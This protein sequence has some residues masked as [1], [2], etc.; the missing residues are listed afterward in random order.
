MELKEATKL[1]EEGVLSRPGKWAD[2]GCGSGLFTYALAT[3]LGRGSTVYA[4][5]RD[6]HSIA[7]IE[8]ER[9]G[10][11]I[12]KHV[13]NFERGELP[14][15]KLDGILLANALHFVQ[16]QELLLLN[17]NTFLG[18]KGRLIVIEYDSTKASK[19]VP[20]PLPFHRLQV[21]TSGWA[22]TRKISTAPSI[23]NSGG[24][25]SAIIEPL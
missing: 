11:K 18:P 1:I 22:L 12:E 23:Y 6:A 21:L 13:L 10:A 20:F 7:T 2:L 15:P 5:D 8:A 19:W 25:Y 24:M 4:V 14:L 3:I 17:L 9:A 16:R